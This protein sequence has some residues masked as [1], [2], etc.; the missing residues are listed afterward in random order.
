MERVRPATL[1]GVGTESKQEGCL[2]E[3]A[4]SAH[5]GGQDG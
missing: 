2:E 5:H 4:V 3:A 1:T